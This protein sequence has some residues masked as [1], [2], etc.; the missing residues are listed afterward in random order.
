MFWHLAGPKET[1]RNELKPCPVLPC[2]INHLYFFFRPCVL[3]L[4]VAEILLLL[5]Q[6]LKNPRTAKATASGTHA[7]FPPPPFAN[8][9]SRISNSVMATAAAGTAKA[10]ALSLL[11]AANNHGDL[12]V[13][14]SSLRQVKELLLSLEP[15]LSAEIFPYLVELHV[16][17]ETLVRK[18]L[19][20]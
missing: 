18:S 14:L 17:P 13:K 6:P 2:C 3:L 12:A 9:A 7:L 8:S 11:A 5:L 10:Q 20:E 4:C 1:F 15:S 16:S 19:I